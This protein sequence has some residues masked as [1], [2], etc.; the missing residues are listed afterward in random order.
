M[1]CLTYGAAG[2]VTTR[3]FLQ[4]AT[5]HLLDRPALRHR[6]LVGSAEERSA[7]LHELLRLAPTPSRSPRTRC[8][9]APAATCPAASVRR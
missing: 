6:F 5:W 3:E 1:E 7:I 4:I 8:A 2:M 9:C